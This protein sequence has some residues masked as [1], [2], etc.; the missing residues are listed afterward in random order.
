MVLITL[1][2]SHKSLIVRGSMLK[3]R[4]RPTGVKSD[5]NIAYMQY[6]KRHLSTN[7]MCLG[8][9]LTP[10]RTHNFCSQN[11]FFYVKKL[12]MILDIMILAT[13]EHVYI[14]TQWYLIDISEMNDHRNVLFE[15]LLLSDKLLVL[16]NMEIALAANNTAVKQNVAGPNIPLS[17]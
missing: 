3:T 10:N 6:F 4:I 14:V 9:Y 7:S 5:P 2:I 13:F 17:S 15:I 16:G 1:I 11:R 8:S 12:I